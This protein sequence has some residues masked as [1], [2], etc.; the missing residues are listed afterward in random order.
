MPNS[1]L[2]RPLAQVNATVFIRV[3]NFEY[4]QK[5]STP[6]LKPVHDEL[7]AGD[8]IMEHILHDT[9]FEEGQP[10]RKE[11]STTVGIRTGASGTEAARGGQPVMRIRVSVEGKPD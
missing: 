4:L 3:Q 7:V 2:S 6:K 11:K 1:P 10:A 9:Q 8:A 5:H